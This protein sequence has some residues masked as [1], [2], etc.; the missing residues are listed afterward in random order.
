[1]AEAIAAPSYG[2][3]TMSQIS[4]AS[5]TVVTVQGT[6][7]VTGATAASPIV[8][9]TGQNHG[10]ST[11]DIVQV[12]G[13]VGN[14][15]ANGSWVITVVDGTHFSLNNS[16]GNAAFVAGGQVTHIGRATAGAAV[17]NTVFPRI[18][19]YCL[20]ARIESLSFGTAVRVQFSDALDSAF[21]TEQCLATSQRIGS[22]GQ[23][24]I[25]GAP[26]NCDTVYSARDCEV[27]DFR[28]GQVGAVA[29]MKLF[30]INAVPGATMTFSGWLSY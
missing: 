5:G 27:P 11:N 29:R 4:F 25:P 12:A 2:D 7:N 1:M 19:S 15:G 20:Q 26:A 13:V 3:P 17:S 28:I 18:P 22:L 21:V 9:R 10:L 30:F 23:A 8:V 6:V 16:V 14:T 24:P